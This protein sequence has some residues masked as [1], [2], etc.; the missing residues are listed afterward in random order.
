MKS[1]TLA[2]FKR[3]RPCWLEDADGAAKLEEIGGRRKRWTA[4]D[5]LDLPSE[6]VS[7]EDKLWAVLRPELIDEAILHEF[8][9]QCAEEALKLVDNPDP[10]S[11]AAIEAKRKWLRGEITDKK[12]DAA[13]AAALDAAR[14]VAF[15]A[16]YAAA[17][18]AA[19]TAACAD[20]SANASANALDAAYAAAF[21]AARAAARAAGRAAAR[22]DARAAARTAACADASA[23]QV[24]MLR[25]MLAA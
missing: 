16:A 18:A 7:A 24:E 6:E 17:Y 15:D 25:G 23:A 21:A 2:E 1:I 22:A 3:F 5:I 12:L 11:V 14:A 19:R 4:L 10:R 20:A 9:C 13:Y 8:A